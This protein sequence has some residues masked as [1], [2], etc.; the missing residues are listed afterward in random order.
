MLLLL[1]HKRKYVFCGYHVASFTLTIVWSIKR[2]K[3]GKNGKGQST[4]KISLRTCGDYVS[5]WR[6]IFL[7]TSLQEDAVKSP[8]KFQLH[9]QTPA[10]H[11]CYYLILSFRFFHSQFYFRSFTDMRIFFFVKGCVNKIVTKMKQQ[12]PALFCYL[13]N[14]VIF[15]LAHYHLFSFLYSTHVTCLIAFFSLSSFA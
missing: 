7:L 6:E 5:L 9:T 12:T 11:K 3:R 14:T 1:Q 2:R 4:N 13:L 10:F 8:I 15:Q